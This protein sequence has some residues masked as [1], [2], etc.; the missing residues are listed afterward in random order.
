MLVVAAAIDGGAGKWLMHRRPPHKQHGGL[1]EFPGGK[2][3]SG[4]APRAALVRELKEELGIN[5][6]E[7]SLTPAAF[8]DSGAAPRE[9]AIVIV[10]YTTAFAQRSVRALEG[11]EVGWF[12]PAEIGD[13]AVPPLDRELAGQLFAR[14]G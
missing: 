12:S 5:L 10:L 1:W 9:Q 4:E 7:A 8:A 13:L 3:E 14:A 6:P 11:G 2:V